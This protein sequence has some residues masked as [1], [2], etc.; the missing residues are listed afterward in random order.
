VAEDDAPALEALVEAATKMLN[1]G[2]TSEVKAAL[3]KAGVNR[4]TELADD[5]EGRKQF[6][7]ALGV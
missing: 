7:S 4:V 1:A 6:A 5:P 2:K 3:A